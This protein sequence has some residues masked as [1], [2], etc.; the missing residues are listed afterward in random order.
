MNNTTNT[1]LSPQEWDELYD[2]D[3]AKWEC[4]YLE[5]MYNRENIGHCERCPENNGNNCNSHKCGQ[6]CCWVT[7]HTR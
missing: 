1:R 6:Q 2:E 7:V 5:F 4:L 3:R